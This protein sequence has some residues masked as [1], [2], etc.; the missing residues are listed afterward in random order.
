MSLDLTD[1]ELTKN[2]YVEKWV[3]LMMMELT[4]NMRDS[5]IMIQIRSIQIVLKS[6]IVKDPASSWTAYPSHVEN[7]VKENWK[8]LDSVPTERER[9]S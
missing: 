8:Y 6:V 4:L 2:S 3:N 7:K 1:L 9:D 5:F